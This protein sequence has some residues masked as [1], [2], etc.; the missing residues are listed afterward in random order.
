MVSVHVEVHA[1]EAAVCHVLQSSYAAGCLS[2]GAVLVSERLAL[3]WVQ[4][5]LLT[6]AF[7]AATPDHACSLHIS[8]VSDSMY[9][10][11]ISCGQE[12]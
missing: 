1:E 5:I 12:G 4:Q 2:H 9:M 6:L 8:Y 10:L 3:F 11:H 7:S